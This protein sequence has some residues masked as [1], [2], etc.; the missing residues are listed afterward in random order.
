MILLRQNQKYINILNL[1]SKFS[2]C[3][4][5]ASASE[6]PARLTACK[7]LFYLS[8]TTFNPSYTTANYNTTGAQIQPINVNTTSQVITGQPTY[9]NSYQTVGNVQ[10]IENYASEQGYEVKPGQQG[11]Y[12]TNVAIGQFGGNLQQLNGTSYQPV[13]GGTYQVGSGNAYA[14]TGATGGGSFTIKPQTVNFG[15]SRAQ[16]I[17]SAQ[18]ASYMQAVNQPATTTYIQPPT[19]QYYQQPLPT[20]YIQPTSYIQPAVTTTYTQPVQE[21]TASYVATQPANQWV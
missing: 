6:H 2:E 4:N 16:T 5:Q 3:H 21:V 19:T 20:Q 12:A 14:A 11:G 13:A 1:K 9:V 15:G 10:R 8:P 7:Q 17:T 18:P